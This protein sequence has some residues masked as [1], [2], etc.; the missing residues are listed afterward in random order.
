P[1]K[2][3]PNESQKAALAAR[4]KQ[5]DEKK[6]TPA[7]DTPSAAPAPTPAPAKPAPA[8][9]PPDVAAL[10]KELD[11]ANGAGR[12]ALV[13]N[14]LARGETARGT[15]ER[16]LGETSFKSDVLR[17]VIARLDAAARA[18]GEKPPT[19]TAS[20]RR[21]V[22]APWVDEKYRLAVDKFLAGDYLGA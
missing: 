17:E 9:P 2:P 11:A 12:R 1:E 6:D 10:L 16:A 22:E 5:I 15:V 7:T 18:R 13:A 19:A 21:S 20:K 8:G 4:Q 14:I 3:E